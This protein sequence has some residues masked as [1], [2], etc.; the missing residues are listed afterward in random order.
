MHSG[1]T[2][3][4]FQDCS[5]GT[6]S[7]FFGRGSWKLSIIKYIYNVV[8]KEYYLSKSMVTASGLNTKIVMEQLR[9]FTALV[10]TVDSGC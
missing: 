2:L 5:R 1:N 4:S 9:V 10:I 7:E 3:H 8:L 6:C